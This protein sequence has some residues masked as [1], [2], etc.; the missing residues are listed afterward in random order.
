M[1]ATE[2]LTSTREGHGWR[3]PAVVAIALRE[4]RGGMSGFRIF[5]ACIALG[6]AVI[7]GVGAVSDA[8]R[9]GF[10]RQ[11]EAILGGD[12]TLSRMH[13]R[14]HGEERDFLESLG[15]LSETATMRTMA[16]RPDGSDQ[17][18]AELKIVDKA[19]PLVGSV[20]L[21][22]GKDCRRRSPRARSSIPCCSSASA[23]KSA[24]A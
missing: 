4:L 12:L 20:V 1:T 19:Y 7:T 8:L 14:A 22:E 24:T 23:S 10:E 9:A 3:L 21:D 11:G 15:R 17:A 18:L 2:A 5:I 6:V 16:R 13:V